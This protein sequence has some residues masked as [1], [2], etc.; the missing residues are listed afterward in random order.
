MPRTASRGLLGLATVLAIV[1]SLLVGRGGAAPTATCTNDQLVPRVA[2]LM[3]TQGAPGYTRLARGK[4]A[5]VRAYLTNPTTCTLSNKQSITPVRA[6]LDTTIS[7]SPAGPQLAN[8]APLAGKLTAVTQIAP[9]S[10]PFFVV[11]SSYLAPTTTTASF[12]V[13]VT[14]TVKYIRTGSTAEQTATAS[15]T[16]TVDQQANALRILVV[17]MGDPAGPSPQWSP[18]AETVLQNAMSD[19]VRALPLPSGAT[20][21]LITPPPTAGARY[22]V[23]GDLLDVRSLNLYR[24]AGNVTKFCANAGNWNTSQVTSGPYTGHTLKGDLQERLDNYNLYNSPPADMVLG[25]IDG[26][27]AFKSTDSGVICDDGRA[28]TPNPTARTPGEVGWVRVDTTTSPTPLQMELLHTLGIVDSTIQPSFH[29]SEVEA[30]GGT[31]KGYNVLERK[32]IA[33]VT[34]ALGVNDHSVMNYSST[35]PY[36]RDNTL[37]VPRD[38]MDALCNLGGLESAGN[39]ANCTISTAIGT[40]LGVAGGASMYHIDGHISGGDVTVTDAN[41]ATG[42]QELGIGAASSPLHLFLCVGSCASATVT[43]DIPLS[44]SSQAPI[45]EGHTVFSGSPPPDTFSALV[46]LVHPTLPTVS[47]T[48]AALRHNG[49]TVFDACAS[50]PAPDVMSTSMATEGTVLRSF[51]PFFPGSGEFPTPTNLCCNGRAIGLDGEHLYVTVAFGTGPTTR[52]YQTRMTDG[53][54]VNSFDAGVVIGALGY[55]PSTGRF[56]GGNYGNGDVYEIELTGTSANKTFLFN[57]NGGAPPV[58]CNNQGPSDILGK[59]I[60][61]LEHLPANFTPSLSERLALSGDVCDRVYFKSLAGADLGQFD[62][63][64]N[65]GITTDGA[66]GLWLA[67]LN[68]PDGEGDT[69]LTHV[70]LNG[71]VLGEL[72]I[73]NYEAEDLAYDAVTFAPT[74]AV[75]MNQATNG[76]PRIQA[77]AVPCAGGDTDTIVVETVNTEFVTLF[78]VCGT[79]TDGTNPNVEKFSLGTYVPANG[80]TIVPVT[81]DR[82]CENATIVAEASNGWS[83]TGLTDAQAGEDTDPPS[84]PPT[85]NIAAPLAGQ[86]YRRRETI[87]FEGTA[88]DSKDGE[89]VSTLKWYDGSTLISEGNGKTSFDY[90]VPANAPLGS[91]VIKL[92]ATDSDGQKGEATVTITIRPAVCPAPGTVHEEQ[93]GEEDDEASSAGLRRDACN[94]DTRDRYRDGGRHEGPAVCEHHR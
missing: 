55:K 30:D 77:V 6:T 14:M 31:N 60:D 1:L 11:P 28:A 85:V 78:A 39:F 38:W 41:T 51:I 57:F 88:F 71:T 56:Y 46:K 70:D 43:R 5:I 19:T 40:N 68:F 76:S 50:D 4:E 91:H 64:N 27:I 75:W 87:H 8:Y 7:G 90:Q 52:I 84:Q 12:T 62:T 3:V 81:D 33:S 20:P 21:Q 69:R 2:E 59:Q 36:R 94:C 17:P 79:Q 65:S 16:A 37:M 53:R 63:D 74:C 82:Y 54:I 22:R 32:V 93:E 47:F 67:R 80:Q 42:D 23:S 66:S 49:A 92:E 61:G 10:D 15:A 35:I 9:T 18:A 58:D 86:S 48:C 29:G 72:V 25:V 45:N 83:S 13:A 44:L 73:Q 26:A 34:G 24:T 89:I